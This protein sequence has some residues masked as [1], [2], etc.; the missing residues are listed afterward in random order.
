M[1]I[2]YLNKILLTL[3]ILGCLNIIR[4][5]YYFIQT[6]VKVDEDNNVKYKLNSKSLILLGLSI[7]YVIATLI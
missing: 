4:H 7:S 3:F 2:T 5:L 1:L 6:W